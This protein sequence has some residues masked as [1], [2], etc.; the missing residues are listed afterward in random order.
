MAMSRLAFNR[1]KAAIMVFLAALSAFPAA[2]DQPPAARADLA[3]E[4]RSGRYSAFLDV[5]Q[6][7][8]T[9][10]ESRNGERSELWTIQGWS[11][12]AAISDVG[13]TLA[14]GHPGNN[15][16]PLDADEDTIVVS[17]YRGGAL[18]RQVKLGEILPIASLRRTISHVEW[19]THVGFDE[20]GRYV[21]ETE[22]K[23]LLAFG[24]QGKPE[25]VGR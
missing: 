8:V 11:P 10:F 3:V 5:G 21:V 13:P 19:G 20:K 7:R 24:L 1:R 18:V 2:A 16:L 22:D 25:T 6:R 14:M 4:S 9:V 15:L 12:V 23:R 17:L